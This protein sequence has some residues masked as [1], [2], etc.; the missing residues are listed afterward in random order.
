MRSVESPTI[1]L[2]IPT[3]SR[4]TLARTLASVAGQLWIPGDEVILVLDGPQPIA[5]ELAGQFHL[6]IRVIEVPGP[7]KNWGHTPRNLVNQS[8]IGTHLMNLD[9][10]DELTGNAV[11][12]VRR[13]IAATPDRPHIFRMSGHPAVGTVWKEKTIREGNVGTPMIVTPNIA[14]KVAQFNPNRYAGDFD[15]IRQTC[16]LY[17]DGPIWNEEVICK[18]RPHDR[19]QTR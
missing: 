9:D 12:V 15:F 13:A 3:V 10:D 6:T 5:R 1:S 14:G 18:V 4:P 2:V 19:G 11:E 16:E 8:A 17:P 7:S